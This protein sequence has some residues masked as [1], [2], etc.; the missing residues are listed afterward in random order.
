MN[1]YVPMAGPL[2]GV[3]YEPSSGTEGM[4]FHEAWCC[5]CKHDKE[6]N[7]TCF[8]ENR[9][10]TDDDYCPILSA[11]FRGEAVEWRDLGERDVCLAFAPMD[12]PT[13]R[14]AHTLELPF[15]EPVIAASGPFA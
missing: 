12:A 10:P 11:S 5:N 8:Q 15:P 4:C 14:C 2:P 9:D 6:M 13:P 3:Q 1:E 7:G